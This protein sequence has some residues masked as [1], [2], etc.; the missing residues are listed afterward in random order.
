VPNRS[1]QGIVP[2]LVTPLREDERI[3]YNAWQVLIDTLIEAGVDGV[4]CGGSSGEF[5]S[6]DPEERVVALR[7][8]RQAVA[9]RVPLYGN[10]GCITTRQTVRLAQTAQAEGVDVIVVVTPYYLK[11]SQ[12]ELAEHYIEVCRAVRM[13]VLA[14]NFPQH[15]G[16]NMEPATL[17]RVAAHCENLVGLKD[18][19]GDVEQSAAYVTCA[20]GREM[21]VFVGPENLLVP[22][23]ERGCV[24]AVTACANI[25]PH[26][27]VQLYRAF[28]VG[29]LSDAAKL[30]GLASEL[31]A[32]AGLH[33]FPSMLKE[34]MR[35]IGM[36]VGKCRKPIGEVPV[37]AREKLAA[38]LEML[39]Q[40]GYLR[41]VGKVVTA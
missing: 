37:A 19:S 11:P 33:T 21:A 6:L 39:R 28:R 23:M 4:F 34:A 20:P 25:A 1:L 31:G 7:F 9:E 13:P 2:A 8:C 29:R 38:V 40:E 27:F 35:M 5:Y 15:G 14:Y 24:G 36:P 3:D 30:Q 32:T 17:G 18:S 22:A 12:Q 16:V 10:V 41:P 26:L